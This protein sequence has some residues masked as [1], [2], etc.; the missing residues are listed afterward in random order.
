MPCMYMQC[1]IILFYL[2]TCVMF[3]IRNK[4]RPTYNKYDNKNIK[5]FYIVKIEERDNSL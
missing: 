1:I 5:I 4:N 2:C 3:Y